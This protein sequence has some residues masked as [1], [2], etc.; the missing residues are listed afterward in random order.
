MQVRLRLVLVLLVLAGSGNFLFAQEV[1][2]PF[3]EE[4]TFEEFIKKQMKEDHIPG[5]SVGVIRDGKVWA[6]GYGYTD[7]ENKVPAHRY[8]VYRLA[9]NTKSM[10]A[11]AILKLYED[12]KINLDEPVHT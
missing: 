1:N 6:K 12:N 11:A 4:N 5:L 8:S 10:T 7:L 2:L 3:E 9:S